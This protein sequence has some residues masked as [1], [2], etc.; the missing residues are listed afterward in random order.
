MKLSEEKLRSLLIKPFRNG[1][2]FT[3]NCPECGK[4]EFGIAINK[5]NHPFNC[6]RKKKCGIE[7]NIYNYLKLTGQRI[8]E[9]PEEKSTQNEL[10]NLNFFQNEQEN[11]LYLP[12]IKKPLGFKRIYSDE[13]LE[14]RGFAK[15]DF[16]TYEIGETN[17]VRK[18]KNY[19]IILLYQE[20]KLVGYVARTVYNKQICEEKG[21]PRYRNSDSDFESIL[22][23]YDQLDQSD[24]VILVEGIFDKIAADKKL[25][26][27]TSILATFGGKVTDNQIKLLRKKGIKNIILL[28]ESDIIEQIKRYSQKLSIHFNVL[29]GDLPRGEDP[30]SLSTEAL[31]EIVNNNKLVLPTNYSL[32]K[33]ESNLQW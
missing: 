23:G 15:Q 25:N 19:K 13:Y 22:G 24:T 21:I 29:I 32:G 27:N 26:T 28:F 17:L 3:A 14:S 12:Q 4:R 16:E 20:N 6:F 18:L 31:N 1:N 5:D 30:D 8:K 2:N 10:L 9:L 11:L 33:L 7:G